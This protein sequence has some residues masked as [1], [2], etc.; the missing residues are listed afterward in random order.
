MLSMLSLCC[1][2]CGIQVRET[3]VTTPTFT[4]ITA[5]LPP[6]S[7]PL[8][9][10]TSLPPLPSPTVAPVAGTAST[11]INV[12]S[13]PS[14]ASEVLGVIA[15]N[16]KV[17]IVGK[18][19]GSNWWQIIYPQGK[20]GK[21][22]VTAKYITTPGKPEVPVIGGADTNTNNSNKAIIQQKLNVRSGPGTDFNSIGTLNAQD[23]VN[24]I[25]KDANGAWLQIEFTAGPEGKG[26][27]NA[28]FVQAKNLEN[29]P[30][31]TEAGDVIGTGTPTLIPPTATA[32]LIPAWLDNDSP[33]QPIANVIF[34]STGTHT[35]I[36]NGDVSA[37][38]GDTDDWIAF[39]SYSHTVLISL[40]CKGSLTIH[41]ELLK[42]N[43]STGMEI[44]CNT[45]LKELTIEPK[46]NYLVHIQA[47]KSNNFLQYTN[48]TITIQT[49]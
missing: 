7:T 17:Q 5:T 40:E 49:R 47:Q 48:Y 42:N 14:T 36:Y 25:G 18:D 46:V 27:V 3:G 28:V 31:I 13:D 39:T 4:I 9:S 29:I 10:Q 1:A 2:G 35:L 45:A 23:M 41:T 19:P 33:S 43:L 6:T 44:A 30:I 20:D 32:T 8:P 21:G 22:W 16:A 37:P 26:W 38:Q 15:A 11:Q 12:R 24:L 34:E